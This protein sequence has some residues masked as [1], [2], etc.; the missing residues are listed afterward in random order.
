M[1]VAKRSVTRPFFLFCWHHL[2][3]MTEWSQNL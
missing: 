1:G 3:N 2:A